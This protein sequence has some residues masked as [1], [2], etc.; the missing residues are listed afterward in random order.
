MKE[1]N[2]VMPETKSLKKYIPIDLPDL[3]RLGVLRDGGY[4][5]ARRQLSETHLVLGLGIG[6]NWTFEQHF[7]ACSPWVSI[8]AVDYS[9]SKCIF[10]MRAIREAATL[11][12]ALCQGHFKKAR[13]QVSFTR[14]YL[15]A[16]IRLR[17][18]ESQTAFIRKKVGRGLSDSEIN[19]KTLF[20]TYASTARNN[21][22]FVKMDIESAEYEVL[23]DFRPFFSKI[24]GFAI[25]FHQLDRYW[26][27]FERVVS[28]LRTD[29]EI[30]HIH[31]N[32]FGKTIPNTQVPATLE[33]TFLHRCLLKDHETV[34]SSQ[35]YPLIG[36]DFPNCVDEKDIDLIFT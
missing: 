25:E 28:V 13:K 22:V 18:L 20:N 26:D 5:M 10:F 24:N 4:V 19:A 31:G 3:I 35:S 29:F 32:N 11:I 16:S 9:I 34:L 21:S 30:I 2:I 33:I 17:W 1:V 8:V 6:S 27:V 14:K 12:L 7:K 36:L 23:E 15:S